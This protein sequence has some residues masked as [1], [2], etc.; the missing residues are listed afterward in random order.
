MYCSAP[1][2][3]TAKNYKDLDQIYTSSM[4]KHWIVRKTG[5]VKACDALQV[6]D[7]TQKFNDWCRILSLTI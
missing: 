6:Y 1:P 2:E 7:T 3:S 4:L 5:W